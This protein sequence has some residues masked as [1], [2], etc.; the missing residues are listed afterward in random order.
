MLR[1]NGWYSHVRRNDLRSVAML[2]GF[3]VAF[4]IIAVV[5]LA[6]PLLNSD[7]AHAP[8][9][10]IG[11]YATRYVPAVFVLGAA[12]FL[13][14]F[15]RHGATVRNAVR[16]T[17]VERRSDPRLVNIVETQAIAA[18]LPP[19][20]VGIIESDACNAF[21]CGLGPRSATIVV[22]RGLVQALDDD[23]LAAVVA[24]EVA[25]IRN[26]DIRLIAAADVLLGNVR[27]MQRQNPIRI[28]G[29][30]QIL[31]IVLVPP[32]LAL[33]LLAG[34]VIGVALTLARVSRLLI[35][36][37]REFVADAEAVRMT[38]DP[39]ALISAL[40]RI[41]G[42]SA[43]PGVTPGA[44]AMMIDGAVDG[45]FAS[46][47]AIGERIAVL[48][49][50]SGDM[51][52][53]RGPR[54]DTRPV[55]Q[56]VA[57]GRPAFGRKGTA[58]AAAPTARDLI[59]RA[60]AGSGDRLIGLTP[61]LG[62]V[63]AVGLAGTLAFQ[64]WSG[65]SADS[66]LSYVR[67][68]AIRAVLTTMWSTENSVG[69]MPGTFRSGG[70]TPGQAKLERQAATDAPGAQCFTTTRYTVGDRG[71]H[72]LTPTDPALVQAFSAGPVPGQPE[73]KLERYLGARAKSVNAVYR[74]GAT[75]G[76]ELDRALLGYVETR[77]LMLEVTHR[78][79]GEPGLRV[80]RAAYD[81]SAEP[82]ILD[83]LR[84][85]LDSRVPAF[86][87]DAQVAGEIRLLVSAPARFIP[88]VA[89]AL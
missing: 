59:R 2:A 73:I 86:A 38:H 87:G 8:I 4:Q 47:P 31:A 22:T 9:P 1:V 7:M 17:L 49:R 64:L 50:L 30:R 60:N 14:Q 68:D 77:K 41:E 34:F 19:P 55:E 84:Q 46:H 36:T 56:V 43:V 26:G 32:L 58:A 62:L 48:V 65:R 40:Q 57:A 35:A 12:L 24:H 80:M 78:F 16:F 10:N 6:L 37:S 5:A 29:Y 53:A 88:C 18:G 28:E 23:E 71:L 27:W 79:F 20:K 82:P 66:A 61:A 69:G 13:F 52:Q 76:A 83:A 45:P 74:A 42:R 39:A 25:H 63:L 67:G 15:L 44:D 3:L 54:R 89:R 72:P 21:A 33:F 75:G 81:T 70:A 51:V 85:R 11:G